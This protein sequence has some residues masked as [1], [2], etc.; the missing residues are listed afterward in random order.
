[1]N[2]HLS[3]ERLQALLDGELPLQE[4]RAAH[5]HVDGCVRCRSEMEAW[6]TLFGELT[7][8][9]KLSPS[10]AFRERIVESL[11][12]RAGAGARVRAWLGLENQAAAHVGSARLQDYMDGRLAART[13]ARVEAHLDS[14]AVCRLELD[15]FQALGRA[16]AGLARLAPCEDFSERVLAG[17]RIR[18]LAET[19]LAPTTRR[20]R[21]LAWIRGA[22]PSSPRGWAAAL[23][24]AVAPVATLA[25]V[26]QTVFSHPLVTVGS[27][28]SF[29][30]LKASTL[31]ERALDAVGA[32]GLESS[33]V[34]RAWEVLRGMLQSP[35]LAAAGAA[36]L[37]GL[38]MAALWILYRNVFASHP[39][40]R[41]YAQLSI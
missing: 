19:A 40:D 35:T 12:R 38:I 18:R 31:A 5:A 20:E 10:P 33:N 34:F 13:A 17:V 4:A 21:V 37:S 1:M 32:S 41:R 30:W 8:L 15:E 7:E 39:E 3:A 28:A 11:P 26:V 25:L 14:C 23:G 16:L 6:E 2:G 36:L 27:L 29:A 22:V 24:A 9:P